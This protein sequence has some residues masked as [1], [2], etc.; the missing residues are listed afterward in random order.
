MTQELNVLALFKGEER[1]VYVYDDD[2]RETLID[3]LRHQAADP[4]VTLNWFDA[5]VLTERVRNPA[6]EESEIDPVVERPR[7]G[8]SVRE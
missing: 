4:A 3:E 8:H 1:F 2:S 6:A 5:A 7:N